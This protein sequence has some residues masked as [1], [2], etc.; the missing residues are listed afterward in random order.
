MLVPP[1][2]A[3]VAPAPTR[4]PLVAAA[5]FEVVRP[6]RTVRV[7]T[8]VVDDGRR[9]LTRRYRTELRYRCGAAPWRV[10]VRTRP[11]RASVRLAWRYGTT[12]RGRD[13]LLQVVVRRA[14]GA[15]AASRPVRRR[16]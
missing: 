4:A 12:A 7:A 3:L 2:P 9:I 13:C 5:A 16:L 11:G 1:P 15:V 14:D 10:A 8:V 6:R